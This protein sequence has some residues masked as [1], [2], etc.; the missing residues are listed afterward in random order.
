[1]AIES[2]YDEDEECDN[3]ARRTI[4]NLTDT[5]ADGVL[6]F[7][8]DGRRFAIAFTATIIAA[9]E[10]EDDE[11]DRY[12]RLEESDITSMTVVACV[13][14]DDKQAP[15]GYVLTAADVEIAKQTINENI[16]LYLQMG[17]QLPEIVLG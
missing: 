13:T 12:K 9:P 8:G 6:S 3:H 15:S 17:G 14:D 16:D 4:M 11:D 2:Y 5:E 10:D 1:M 7:K